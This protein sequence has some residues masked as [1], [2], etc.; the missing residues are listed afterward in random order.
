[1]KRTKKVEVNSKKELK[2]ALNWFKK[3]F[4]NSSKKDLQKFERAITKDKNK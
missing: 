1:M 3:R 2:Q 4:P